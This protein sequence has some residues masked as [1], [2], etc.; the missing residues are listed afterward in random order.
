[1][2]YKT[3]E[4]NH[5][6]L[7]LNSRK[8][9]PR[10]TVTVQVTRGDTEAAKQ[11]AQGNAQEKGVIEK[12]LTSVAL[13]ER[14]NRV[15]QASMVKL[16]ESKNT[17][18]DKAD[19][20]P[21]TP[22]PSTKTKGHATKQ[23]VPEVQ[24]EDAADAQEQKEKQLKR[25]QAN[26][27]RRETLQKRAQLN[28]ERTEEV[29]QYALPRDAEALRDAVSKKVNVL[30][31]ADPITRCLLVSYI[32]SVFACRKVERLSG[33]VSMTTTNKRELDNLLKKVEK[34]GGQMK[35]CEDDVKVLNDCVMIKDVGKDANKQFLEISLAPLNAHFEQEEL[36]EINGKNA[37]RSLT[38][39]DHLN[40]RAIKRAYESMVLKIACPL[41][42]NIMTDEG[43][44]QLQMVNNFM[45]EMFQKKRGG[46]CEYV[47]LLQSM[48]IISA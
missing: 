45:C 7:G 15:K 41:A 42:K 19:V 28:T 21:T 10:N 6:L 34:S 13:E 40:G 3:T 26:Q 24:K 22:P 18:P 16:P 2:K 32:I 4:K 31:D 25:E 8:T 9:M 11:K 36:K 20:F 5:T 33:I 38:T 47:R 48:D 29:L 35:L 23:A 37:K 1:M 46:E 17:K 30:K 12:A 43:L 14:G 44:R 27:K 39:I